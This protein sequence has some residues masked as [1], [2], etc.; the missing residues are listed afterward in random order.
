MVEKFKNIGI[1]IDVNEIEY[2]FGD[3]VICRSHIADL[4]IDK[5]IVGTAREAFLKY[6]GANKVCYVPKESKSTGEVISFI[7][8]AGG[9]PVLAHPSTSKANEWIPALIEEGLIGIEV[10]YPTHSS[11]EIESY[12]EIAKK[13]ALIPTGGSDS[14]GAREKYV[15]IGDFYVTDEILS[16][17]YERRA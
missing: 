11:A 1:E 6:L 12:L 14:H 15:G 17:L 4:L 9:I 16:Y 3:G 7:L 5:G 13:Y 2:H 10:W 8:D